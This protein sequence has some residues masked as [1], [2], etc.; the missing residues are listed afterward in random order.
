MVYVRYSI[1]LRQNQLLNKRPESSNISLD[2]FDP[3]SRWV[4]ETEEPIVN[5][6]DLSW[7]DL[8][9]L[10]T[11]PSGPGESSQ[12]PTINPQ[13]ATANSEGED[14]GEAEVVDSD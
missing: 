11:P 3:S 8:D 12:N 10:P 1:W 5:N 2:D 6:E 7:M 14:E 13:S 4:V 9:P